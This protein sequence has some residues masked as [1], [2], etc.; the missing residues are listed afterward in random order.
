MTIIKALLVMLL[1]ILLESLG[2]I[3][4]VI[5]NL[6]FIRFT[7]VAPYIFF[8]M[9][10]LIKYFVIIILL[11]RYSIGAYEVT[12]KQRLNIK[13]FICVALIIIGFRI[14]FD[15]SLIYL[16]DKIPMPDFVNE[17]FD[18]LSIS[19]VILILRVT[20][21]APIYE[22]VIFR[23]ILLKGMANKINPK[24]ALVVSALFFAM[25]HMNIPQ[26]I[27]AFLLGLL[28]G[29][30]YLNTGSIY[31]CIFAHFINNSLGISISEAFQFVNGE[32]AILIHCISFI[33]GVIILTI[34][35]RILNQNK[36][37]T[38]SGIYK[39]FTEL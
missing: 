23:G 1:S 14:T 18:Q 22:E 27:N 38:M 3:P 33:T 16:V 37:R 21:I 13:K 12:H 4:I 17:A 25:A 32:Y 7:N 26:G 11:K 2:Q 6:F 9:G 28:I 5:F 29:A 15:N 19:P 34:A 24:L 8:A 30:I 35:Y 10:V 39:E 20:V 36:K 31:L